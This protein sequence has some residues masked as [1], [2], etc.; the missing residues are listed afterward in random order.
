MQR[1]AT[2]QV[3]TDLILAFKVF[4]G[5]IDLTPPDFFFHQPRAGLTWHTYRLLQGPGRREILEQIAGASNQVTLSVRWTGNGSQ[6]SLKHLLTFTTPPQIDLA[7]ETQQVVFWCGT[8][9][10]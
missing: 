7:D 2:R 8:T 4:K 6:S 5:E 9:A 10:R 3:R 1:L